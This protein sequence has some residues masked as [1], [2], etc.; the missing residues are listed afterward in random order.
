MEW[1][2]RRVFELV[3]MR[4]SRRAVRL[5]RERLY[6]SKSGRLRWFIRYKN[7]VAS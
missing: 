7:Q 6:Y 2:E 3:M 5:E 4:T 1:Y